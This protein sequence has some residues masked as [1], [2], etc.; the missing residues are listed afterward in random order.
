MPDRNRD[1]VLPGICNLLLTG[2][3]LLALSG[4]TL[5]D[6]IASNERRDGDGVQSSYLIVAHHLEVMRQLSYGDYHTRVAVF[7]RVVEEAESIPTL[8]NRLTHALALATEGHPATNRPEGFIE[9]GDLLKDSTALLPE[10]RDLAR[11]KL[12]ELETSMI[13]RAENAQLTEKQFKAQLAA[14]NVERR[15]RAAAA[16]EMQKQISDLEA[17]NSR[18]RIELDDALRKLEALSSIERATQ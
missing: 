15:N 17:E 11:V 14:R 8:S 4:C 6:S 2:V 7:N 3:V 12:S 1:S 5:L 16:G 10:E 9:L 18:L 13:L